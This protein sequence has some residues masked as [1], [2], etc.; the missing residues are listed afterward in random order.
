M[1]SVIEKRGTPPGK[2]RNYKNFRYELIY[3][4]E[5][6]E[7]IHKKYRSSTELIEDDSNP[8][9]SCPLL[10]YYVRVKPNKTKLGTE[11]YIIKI[12]KINEPISQP[13]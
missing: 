5:K 3:V 10:Y 6:K 11:K 13:V 1:S 12:K 7:L 4:N 9:T 8:I 2:K